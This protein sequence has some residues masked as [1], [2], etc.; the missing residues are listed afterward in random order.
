MVEVGV[1]GFG[2]EE[3]VVESKRECLNIWGNI[4]KPKSR[5]KRGNVENGKRIKRNNL[6]ERVKNVPEKGSDGR[7]NLQRKTPEMKRNVGKNQR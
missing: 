2:H 1:G 6:V 7:R 4:K 5:K 3:F